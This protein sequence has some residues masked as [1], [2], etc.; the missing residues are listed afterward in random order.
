MASIHRSI[1]AHRV[2]I[3]RLWGDEEQHPAGPGWS[4]CRMHPFG[5]LSGSPAQNLASTM[6]DCRFWSS[7]PITSG[8]DSSSVQVTWR[9]PGDSRLGH[10][11]RPGNHQPTAPIMELGG[12][13]GWPGALGCPA[14]H[15][16]RSP[17]TS[18][19]GGSSYAYTP[20]SRHIGGRPDPSGRTGRPRSARCRRASRLRRP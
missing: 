16:G 10:T 20:V 6:R 12:G 19:Q 13:R 4:N 8:L 14:P 15:R 9:P 2:A 7:H 5:W 17:E 18:T 3:Q 1:S 11:A